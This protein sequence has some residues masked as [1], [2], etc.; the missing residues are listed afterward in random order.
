MIAKTFIVLFIIA[1]LFSLGSA[2]Y[3]LMHDRGDST[4]MV[5]ALTFRIGLSVILFILLMVGFATG[6]LKPNHI[7]LYEPVTTH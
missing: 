2:L 1:I 5:K 6:I 3:Y 7:A 4:R